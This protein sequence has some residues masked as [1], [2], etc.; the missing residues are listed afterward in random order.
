MS[1]IA[2]GDGLTDPAN[3]MDYG[4]FLFQTGLLDEE[5]TKAVEDI[6]EKAKES[7]RQGK[8]EQASDVSTLRETLRSERLLIINHGRICQEFGEI[9]DV[10]TNESSLHF[11]YNFILSEQPKDF[12][13]YLP[14]LQKPE[15]R[16]KN[17]LEDI[18]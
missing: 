15:V 6:T 8:W 3:Q 9:I 5:D 4:E 2:I 7:I 13:N 18:E 11:Y 16:I 14:F 17:V 12:D 10:F 1:G